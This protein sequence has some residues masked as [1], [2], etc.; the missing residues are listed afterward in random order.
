MGCC[1]TP[2]FDGWFTWRYTDDTAYRLP[3]TLKSDSVP[4]KWTG[5]RGIKLPGLPSVNITVN[6]DCTDSTLKYAKGIIKV[7]LG[8]DT[9]RIK[10]LPTVLSCAVGDKTEWPMLFGRGLGSVCFY[11]IAKS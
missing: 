7:K 6:L 4:G 5:K 9:F 1:T 2:I 10:L 8:T 3:V 11:I